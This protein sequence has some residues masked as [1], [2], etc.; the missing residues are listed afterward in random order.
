MVETTSPYYWVPFGHP[1]DQRSA[2]FIFRWHFTGY[3]VACIIIWSMYNVV[4]IEH[5]L[6]VSEFVSA[7]ELVIS[8]YALRIRMNYLISWYACHVLGY[9][10]FQKKIKRADILV[11][12]NLVGLIRRF[13]IIY[14]EKRK[15]LLQ[16]VGLLYYARKSLALHLW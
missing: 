7:I 4:T 13:G 10:S 1:T 12:I 5:E 16:H 11:A 6:C 15:P 3:N 8:N 9:I 2:N 14:G